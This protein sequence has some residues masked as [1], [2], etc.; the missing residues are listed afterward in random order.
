VESLGHH[1]GT[2][3]H[4]SGCR[5]LWHSSNGNLLIEWPVKVVNYRRRKTICTAIAAALHCTC[6]TI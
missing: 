1:K 4:S 2:F 6:P 3:G 5:N